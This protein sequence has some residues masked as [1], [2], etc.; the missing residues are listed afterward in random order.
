[1]EHQQYDNKVIVLMIIH[2][3][4]C[5]SVFYNIQYEFDDHILKLF[6]QQEHDMDHVDLVFQ[7][8]IV[9]YMNDHMIILQDIFYDKLY[10]H[11]LKKRRFFFKKNSSF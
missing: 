5:Q 10:R 6:F 9:L 11:V 8:D 2:Y 1:M 7:H 4:Y 3:N